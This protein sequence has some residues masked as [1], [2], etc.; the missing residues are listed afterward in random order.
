MS[1][2]TKTGWHVIL[3]GVLGLRVTSRT[4][5]DGTC[6][7]KLAILVATST[8]AIETHADLAALSINWTLPSF[9]IA[10]FAC[11]IVIQPGEFVWNVH[12]MKVKTLLLLTTVGFEDLALPAFPADGKSLSKKT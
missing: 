4:A 10:R 5:S 2:L 1:L 6:M 9:A 3:V 7:H 12:R 11:F 8:C